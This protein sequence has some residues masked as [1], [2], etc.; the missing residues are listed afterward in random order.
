MC[1]HL[2]VSIAPDTN[3][4]ECETLCELVGSVPMAIK[5]LTSLLKP[6]KSGAYSMR[7]VIVNLQKDLENKFQMIEEAGDHVKE[8]I[9]S[10]IKLAY[11]SLEHQYQ[12][13][14]LLLAK[15]YFRTHPVISELIL[16][17]FLILC[18]N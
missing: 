7:N 13:C 5:V 8:R 12:M 17:L 1:V 18:K 16:V 9:I 6:G 4:T 11:D 15:L 3:I 14:S 10:A 2:T